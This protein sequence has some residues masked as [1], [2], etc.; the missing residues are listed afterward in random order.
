MANELKEYQY[1]KYTLIGIGYGIVAIFIVVFLL[2]LTKGFLLNK[3]LQ[4]PYWASIVALIS[5]LP[6]VLPFA[7]K[8]LVS[9]LTSIK[10]LNGI[11]LN[12]ALNNPLYQLITGEKYLW[13]YW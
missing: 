12:F 8:F 9:R 10:I 1:D 5:V 11:Q 7:L 4:Q 3:D 13:I 2:L 6:I